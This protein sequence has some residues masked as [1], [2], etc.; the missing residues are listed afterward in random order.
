M[1]TQRRG[2]PFQIYQTFTATAAETTKLAQYKV[3]Q[4]LL[5]D[6]PLCELRAFKL[7]FQSTAK[8]SIV[9]VRT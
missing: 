7:G 6:F 8:N 9:A 4:K 3:N 2:V 1:F 5:L